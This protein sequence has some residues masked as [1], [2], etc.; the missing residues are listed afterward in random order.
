MSLNYGRLN[1]CS[2]VSAFWTKTGSARRV[3]RKGARSALP[4]CPLPVRRYRG[5]R[6]ECHPL[7]FAHLVD[8]HA[9]FE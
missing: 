9:S 8:F 3:H 1:K 2:F 5:W 6:R 4:L 7:E